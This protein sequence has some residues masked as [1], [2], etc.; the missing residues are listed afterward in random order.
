MKVVGQHLLAVCW[1]ATHHADNPAFAPWRRYVGERGWCS[2]LKLPP[3]RS[4]AR[5]NSRQ[6]CPR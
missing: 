6:V 1:Y 2:E 5:A 4:V 3:P